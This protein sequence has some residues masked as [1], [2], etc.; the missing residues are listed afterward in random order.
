MNQNRH[1]FDRETWERREH[2]TYYTEKLPVAYSL[3][4]ELDI[5]RLLAGLRAQG[6]KLYPALIWC[7]ARAV[8]KNGNFR[9]CRDGEGNLWQ[10]ELSHPNYTIFHEDDHTF[11]D[12]WSEFDD[13]FAVFYD[14]VSA[15]LAEFGNNK[16]PK[17]KPNQP[18]NFFCVSCIPWMSFTGYSTSN[19]L[20]AA[21]FPIILF[22][23]YFERDGKT[24]IPCSLSISHAVA[25]GWHTCE[26]FRTMQEEMDVLY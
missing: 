21:W 9:L 23:K 1:P 6:K 5:T 24:M 8:N 2:F 17:V 13:D 16:G 20:G 7:A 15:D 14:R 10:W 26:L 19:S 25:D 3:T 22:G 11:S 12:M 4:V 18:P